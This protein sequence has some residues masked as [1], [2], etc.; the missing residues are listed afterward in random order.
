MQATVAVVARDGLRG[1]SQRAVAREAG[2]ASSLIAHHFGSSEGL[3]RATLEMAAEVSIARELEDVTGDV[4]ALGRG[5]AR[6]V[7]ADPDLQAFQFEML[8]EARRRPEL[9][10]LLQRVYDAYRNGVRRELMRM[11]Y[12][13]P[14]DALARAVFALM[15]GLVLQQVVFDEPAQTERTLERMRLLLQDARGAASQPA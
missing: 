11:G 2:V 3:L 14:T 8:L 4:E 6:D 5:L 15:D 9:R 13:E 1:F 10:P 12:D 7:A